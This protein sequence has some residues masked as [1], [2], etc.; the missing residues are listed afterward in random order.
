MSLWAIFILTSHI[1]SPS[2]YS[3]M[4]SLYFLSRIMIFFNE[5]TDY[6]FNRAL[7][8]EMFLVRI[9]KSDEN[10]FSGI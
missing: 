6:S 3:L 2:G 1:G 10:S 7:M 5:R 8:Q 4:P 9:S